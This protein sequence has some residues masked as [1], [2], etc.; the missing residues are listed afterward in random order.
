MSRAIFSFPSSRIQNPAKITLAMMTLAN[1]ICARISDVAPPKT[2]SITPVS[3]PK[4]VKAAKIKLFRLIAFKHN[5]PF[6]QDFI[7]RE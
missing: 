4:P 2:R 1:N 3:M 5:P 6:W 7:R